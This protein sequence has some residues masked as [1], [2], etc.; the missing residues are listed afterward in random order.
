V[1]KEAEARRLKAAEDERVKRELEQKEQE[2]KDAEAREIERQRVEAEQRLKQEQ[3]DQRRREEDQKNAILAE[4]EAKKLFDE[5]QSSRQQN[6]AATNAREPLPKNLDSKMQ[7]ITAFNRKLR[8]LSEHPAD[9]LIKELRALNLRLYVGEVVAALVE[10]K[11][12]KTSDVAK[13]RH[14]CSVMHQ[15][16]ADFAPALLPALMAVLKPGK[17][18][19]KASSSSSASSAAGGGAGLASGGGS[20]GSDASSGGA[21]G[22]SDES[23]IAADKEALEALRSA[24]ARKRSL[25]RLL[26]ELW[27]VGIVT[28][29]APVMGVVREAIQVD[30]A[31]KPDPEHTQL[32]LVVSFLRYAG[33]EVLGVLSRKHKQSLTLAGLAAPIANRCQ[34][35]LLTEPQQRTA[36]GLLEEYWNTISKR[37]VSSTVAV[38]KREAK[39][40]RMQVM[41]GDLP[42]DIVARYS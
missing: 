2:R 21:G 11:L 34:Y 23:K 33:E 36:R 8:V 25:L 13:A 40:R 15:H 3:E 28:E 27:L 39:N 41:Q 14:I 29:P 4:N 12:A 7:R 35:G 24:A 16:Y 30:T 26:T 18:G 17:D 32:T 19:S 22:G 38:R 20:A 37:Y 9:A 42:A 6:L 5:L 31:S 1:D 10:T